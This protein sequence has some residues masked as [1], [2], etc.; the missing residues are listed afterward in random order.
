M[1]PVSEWLSATKRQQQVTAD[2]Y[3]VWPG[4]GI[5]GQDAFGNILFQ[6]NTPLRQSIAASRVK[7]FYPRT[8]EDLARVDLAWEI[9]EDA[10]ENTSE[11]PDFSTSAP[12]TQDIPPPKPRTLSRVEIAQQPGF[13]RNEYEQYNE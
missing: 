13:N 7:K 5:L 1:R 4:Q 3:L 12:Y 9:E 8:I 2:T 11:T 10:L 6:D